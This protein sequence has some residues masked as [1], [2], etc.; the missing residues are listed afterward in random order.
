MDAHGCARGGPTLYTIPQSLTL[1]VKSHQGKLH[2]H[3]SSGSTYRV[4]TVL[5]LIIQMCEYIFRYL[6]SCLLEIVFCVN[7]F[8]L[9]E[10]FLCPLFVLEIT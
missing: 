3:F 8:E 2:Q 5:V 7:I 1:A 9:W 6:S 10:P 4:G